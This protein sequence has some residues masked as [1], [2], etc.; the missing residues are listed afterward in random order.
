MS[1]ADIAKLE[2]MSQRFGFVHILN[3][4]AEVYV[5]NGQVNK[6][7]RMMLTLQRLHPDAY[8]AYFDY[9]KAQS[10]LNSRYRT[11]F[12]QMPKRDSAAR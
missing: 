9:W 1:A 4:L 3:K 12:E 11:V 8:P 10:V 2:R 6:A 5:L 7:G